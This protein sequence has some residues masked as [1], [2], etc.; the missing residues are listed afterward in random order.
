MKFGNSPL[1]Q[2]FR[3]GRPDRVAWVI[4]ACMSVCAAWIISMNFSESVQMATLR[5]FHLATENFSLWALQQVSPAMYNFA[6]EGLVQ[7]KQMPMDKLV[8]ISHPPAGY[9]NHYPVRPLTWA[10][11]NQIPACGYWGIFRS[12]F[13]NLE[14]RTKYH[15]TRDENDLGWHLQLIRS[16]MRHGE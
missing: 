8:G 14:F 11:R 2:A 1:L 10:F 15:L 16:S 4:Y 5:R 12:R 6:N 9:F 13:R 3:S 7:E